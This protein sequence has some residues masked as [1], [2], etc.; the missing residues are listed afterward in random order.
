MK[1][2][3]GTAAKRKRS[4]AIANGAISRKAH[5]DRYEGK[6]QQGDDSQGQSQDRA[7]KGAFS[8]DVIPAQPGNAESFP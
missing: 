1:N 6:A 7:A 5:F 3:S 8:I 2:M 4:A